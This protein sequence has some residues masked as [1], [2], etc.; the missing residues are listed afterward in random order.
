V[1][2]TLDK[3]KK[4]RKEGFRKDLLG[5]SKIF[6]RRWML[7]GMRSPSWKILSSCKIAYPSIGLLNVFHAL[8]NEKVV[9]EYFLVMR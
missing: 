6:R 8:K 1:G 4:N 3:N 7:E 5:F 9:I 2:V